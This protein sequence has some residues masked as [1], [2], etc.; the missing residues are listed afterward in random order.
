[1]PPEGDNLFPRIYTNYGM[2]SDHSVEGFD[3]YIDFTNE[4]WIMYYFTE[5]N[6]YQQKRTILKNVYSCTI[7]W[8]LENVPWRLSSTVQGTD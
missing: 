4:E 7:L 8:K 3:N 2:E 5:T 6:F 1:M